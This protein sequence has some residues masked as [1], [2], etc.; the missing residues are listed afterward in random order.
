MTTIDDEGG[1]VFKAVAPRVLSLEDVI[2]LDEVKDE[3]RTQV[4]LWAHADRLTNLG[5]SP[6]IGF[7]FC[8]PPGTGKTTCA[9]AL[10]AETNRELYAFSGTEFYGDTGKERLSQVLDRLA[11][12]PAI[13][14][15][16]DADELL[17]ARDFE[18]DE[19]AE[20]MVR[21]LLAGLDRTVRDI[22]AFFVFATNMPP[23]FVEPALCHAGRLGRPLI[24]R[25]LD[26]D[27][28]LDLLRHV[29]LRFRLAGDVDLEPIAVRLASVPTADLV[30]IF[31]EAASVAWRL[32]HEEIT[33][34]D[35]QEA[36][37]RFVAG[38]ARKR[39]PAA[40]EIQRTA[41]HE[42]GHALFRLVEVG[43]WDA[44]GFV[45]VSAR[46]EGQLGSTDYDEFDVETHTRERIV[47]IIAEGLAG[48]EAERLLL[49]SVSSGAAAD[50]QRVNALADRAAGDWGLSTRGART[51]YGHHPGDISESRID[52][53]AAEL[54]REGEALAQSVLSEH[55][56]ALRLL[57]DRLS[58]HRF[59]DARTLE[60][61]LSNSLTL[62]H[63]P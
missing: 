39:P 62:G 18:D 5:G 17:R 31:D 2:G 13:V 10:A 48:R 29:A 49:G 51:F 11:H 25:A 33:Q 3:L 14:L 56:A 35:L 63:D 8:G 53:A 42:A 41:V 45:Q 12:E 26:P 52:D 44:I 28:R 50:L 55:D 23:N 58:E 61:W 16:D 7:T 21:F 9:H 4:E 57:T 19:Y 60:A 59:A 54:V 15:I 46:N 30:H 40:D 20:N 32:N 38:L 34:G 37:T 27:E 43:R 22:A 6:R 24:F 47:A 1:L 36:V